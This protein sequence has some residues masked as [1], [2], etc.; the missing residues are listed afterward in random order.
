MSIVEYV[1]EHY[2]NPEY[3]VTGQIKYGKNMSIS[4]QQFCAWKRLVEENGQNGWS[5]G[6]SHNH[7]L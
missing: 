4:E 6:H 7:S 3:F 2:N 1:Q 5:Y